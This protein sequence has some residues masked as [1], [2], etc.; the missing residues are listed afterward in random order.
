MKAERTELE[1]LEKEL[2]TGAVNKETYKRILEVS[3]NQ[4]VQFS[5]DKE[6]NFLKK[7]RKSEKERVA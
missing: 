3:S 6:L 4:E 1:K 2:S 7:M 5:L